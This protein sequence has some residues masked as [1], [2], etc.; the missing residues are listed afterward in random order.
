M[1]G[2]MVLLEPVTKNLSIRQEEQ[3]KKNWRKIKHV[4][5]SHNQIIYCKYFTIS[6]IA[7]LTCHTYRVMYVAVSPDGQTIVTGAGDETVRF[8]N[9]F[10]SMKTQFLYAERG[11][12]VGSAQ[13]IWQDSISV[14]IGPTRRSHCRS[15]GSPLF[16]K[17]NSNKQSIET[18]SEAFVSPSLYE[19]EGERAGVPVTSRLFEAMH[20]CIVSPCTGMEI[21]GVCLEARN[22][23]QLEIAY[24][25]KVWCR[26]RF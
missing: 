6:K 15:P 22:I 23:K 19:L 10:P 7:T 21:I 13:R 3:A 18:P 20:T 12:A 2:L 5:C 25:N 9:V 26:R 8:W 24:R 17:N 11:I 1:L 14:L 16:L 4:R